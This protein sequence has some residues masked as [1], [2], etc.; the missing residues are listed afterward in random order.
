MWILLFLCR[1][2]DSK[3]PTT[4]EIDFELAILG[5][6]GS[7]LH[8]L[9]VFQHAY[10]KAHTYGFSS[11][12]ERKSV[13]AKTSTYL[14]QGS[15]II[16]CRMWNGTTEAKMDGQCIAR[17]RIGVER[18]TFLWKIEHFSTFD[19]GNNVALKLKST[20]DDKPIMFLNLF[21]NKPLCLSVILIQLVLE[22]THIVFSTFESSIVDA[23]GDYVNC[24]NQEFWFTPT[25]Q[26]EECT[27]Y[28][29]KDTLMNENYLYLPNDILTL[30]CEVSFSTGIVVEE[31]EST[32]FGCF[33]SIRNN[34]TVPENIKTINVKKPDLGSSNL[35][36]NLN[37]MLQD[38]ILCDIKLCTESEILSAHWFILTAR[39]PVFRAMFESDMK[40]KAKDT[41]SV[42]DLEPDTVRRLL[43][44]LYTDTLEELHW[45]AASD[46]YVAAE[47]YQILTLKDK[48]SSF[49]KANLSLT[50]ACEVLL[51]AALHHDK[52]LKSTVQDFILENDKSVVNSSKWDLLMKANVHLAA[53]T[54][55]LMF[56]K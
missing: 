53:E 34:R 14:P 49:L 16:K 7:V 37:S 9:N 24:C 26:N 46:L 51:L 39:S 23:Q 47:T 44:Y 28:L 52:E 4:I 21:L 50:N 13:L 45:E 15:L 38:N 11:F 5:L 41:I 17:T 31:I 55:L 25:V 29:S 33:D 35:K 8:S 2:Q 12:H 22:N 6:D 43:L 27:L 56:K 36:M 18:K 42:V 10:M 20:S 19:V 30:Y 40:E 32:S 3:G 1:E 54:M 48:C